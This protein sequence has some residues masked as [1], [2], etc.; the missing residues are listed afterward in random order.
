MTRLAMGMSDLPP[1][2]A[3]S[4]WLAPL[5]RRQPGS[6]LWRV[7]AWY[8][9]HA[10]CFVWFTLCYRYRGWGVQRIPE[11]GPLL[12]VANHQS[13][14]DPIIVGLAGHKRQFHALARATLFHNRFFAGLIRLLN[15]IP[16][17][18]GAGDTRAMRT[19]VDVL[20]KGHAL[21]VFPEGARTLTGATEPFATGTWLL[22]KRA[23]PRV[24]PVAIE[25]AYDIW[26]RKSK[27]PRPFGRIG[28]M[29]GRPIDPDE[30]LAHDAD[31]GLEL[32]RHRVESM[33]LDLREKLRRG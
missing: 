21:L 3:D 30:L 29:I 11:T 33:R 2:D 16:V 32:L 27:L 12:I 24:L 9:M 28:Y 14:Y 15:A 7:F 6:P 5:R 18:Q 17:E 1:P 25:G 10:V 4:S 26:P 23:R 22:I 13:F 31:E 19:S 8:A 20:K